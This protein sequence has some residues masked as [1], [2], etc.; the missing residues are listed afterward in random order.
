M[1]S[2]KHDCRKIFHLIYRHF[3]TDESAY[4]IDAISVVPLGKRR[5][6]STRHEPDHCGSFKAKP[7]S[8]YSNVL[9][10]THR[11]E[12]LWS[13]HATIADFDPTIEL[14]MVSKDFEGWLDRG[15]FRHLCQDKIRS[16]LRVWVVSWFE[17]HLLYSH[18]LEKDSHET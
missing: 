15:E 11:L 17:A 6:I 3:V 10:E 9:W 12:H 4:I 13:K 18:L 16:Y 1:A 14:R 7:P 2:L 5:R 8:M